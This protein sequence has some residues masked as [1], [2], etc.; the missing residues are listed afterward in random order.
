[1]GLL[2]AVALLNVRA[3]FFDFAA[4]CR[5]GGD[6]QTRFASYLGSFLHTVDREASVY[7]LSDDLLQYGTHSSVDF[8]SGGLPVTNQPGPVQDIVVE[9][10]TA[11]IAIAARAD[12][13]RAWARANPGGHLE[14]HYDC[15]ALMLMA[16]V[17]PE[18]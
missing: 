15:D 9:P 18:N 7:L 13:L 2:A 10:N 1:L 12:E 3:Y 8:L 6:T 14:R 11:V 4:Q 5:F 16:Y 17:I